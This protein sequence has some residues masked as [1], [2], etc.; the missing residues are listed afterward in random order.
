MAAV[1]FRDTRETA[2]RSAQVRADA[3]ERKAMAFGCLPIQAAKPHPLRGSP[4]CR[5]EERGQLFES[6][7][8][9]AGRGNAQVVVPGL[10]LAL[11]ELGAEQCDRRAGRFRRSKE[12]GGILDCR[13]AG[14][15]AVVAFERAKP[16][17]LV[18]PNITA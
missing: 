11:A 9:V 18:A 6:R 8:R 12:L 14:V 13:K 16:A 10:I 4:G 15:V 2:A 1:R 5:A 7:R 3:F 17:E